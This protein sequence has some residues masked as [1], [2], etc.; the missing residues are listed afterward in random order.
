MEAL[1]HDEVFDF[2][3]I[4]CVLFFRYRQ[5]Q[6]DWKISIAIVWIL[7][8]YHQ[9]FTTLEYLLKKKLQQTPQ[10][11]HFFLFEKH[12]VSP[13]WVVKRWRPWEFA[14]H[15]AIN[16]TAKSTCPFFIQKSPTASF[17]GGDFPLT[18][19]HEKL[20]YNEFDCEN[21]SR[22]FYNEFDCGKISL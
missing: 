2:E 13:N 19:E 18:G 1:I 14:V 9:K 11:R 21:F 17:S 15:C 6:N 20:F 5:A 7:K 22:F 16:I 8:M 10:G 3:V 4:I 12:W